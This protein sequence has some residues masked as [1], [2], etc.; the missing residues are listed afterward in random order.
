MPQEVSFSFLVWLKAVKELFLYVFGCS[1]NYS[2]NHLVRR[3]KRKVKIFK[4]GTSTYS[5]VLL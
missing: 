1:S 4:K 5:C 2:E 3:E